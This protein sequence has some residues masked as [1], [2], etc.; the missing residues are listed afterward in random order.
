VVYACHIYAR[1][2]FQDFSHRILLCVDFQN[3]A[4]ICLVQAGLQMSEFSW[5]RW[6][7]IF[8]Q[9][10]LDSIDCSDAH[11]HLDRYNFRAD[12]LLLV[13]IMDLTS[14]GVSFETFFFRLAIPYR[15]G[16]IYKCQGFRTLHYIDAIRKDFIPQLNTRQIR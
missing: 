7:F 8:H 16:R 6:L 13:R 5:C 11:L 15:S 14:A 1:L 3:E 9:M 10:C 4:L 2:S 12:I